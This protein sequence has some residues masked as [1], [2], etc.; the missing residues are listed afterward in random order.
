MTRHWVPGYGHDVQQYYWR[1]HLVRVIN[2]RQRPVL[3]LDVSRLRGRR[4]PQDGEGVEPLDLSVIRH[5]VHEVEEARPSRDQRQQL[6]DR[7]ID[8]STDSRV[9]G[10]STPRGWKGRRR[11]AAKEML[12]ANG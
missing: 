6:M 5:G 8:T 10:A 9:Q 7:Y 2:E 4:D 11:E 12:D 1:T 3:L